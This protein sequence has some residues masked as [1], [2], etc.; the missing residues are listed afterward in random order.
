M[1]YKFKTVTVNNFSQLNEELRDFLVSDVGWTDETPSGQD[2][3]MGA[4]DYHGILGTFLRSSGEDGNQDIRL[5]LHQEQSDDDATV[6]YRTG[7]LPAFSYLSGTLAIG[8]SSVSVD[9][10]TE[11]AAVTTPFVVR[12]N[13]ELAVVSNVSGGTVTFSLRGAYGTAEAA[14]DASDVILNVSYSLPRIDVYAYRD[15]ATALASSSGTS[16]LGKKSVTGVPGLSGYTDDEFNLH[17]MLKVTDGAEA[18][19]MRPILDYAGTGGDFDYVAFSKAPGTANCE[20]VSMGFLPTNSKK[21]NNG[22]NRVQPLVR[23]AE[24]GT[25]TPCWFYASKDAVWVITKW[26]TGYDSFFAGNVIPSSSRDTTTSVG[27]STAGTASIDVVNRHLFVEG[28][29][30]RIISQNAD[31]WATNYSRSGGEPDLDA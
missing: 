10:D 23:M 15:L 21:V 30:F 19:K 14:H 29:K 24:A 1:A 7:R 18:G 2:D 28:E 4:G 11:L 6:E 3:E 31:D 12:M 26:N 25:D 27:T 5:H 17:G 8:A 9:D 22:G 16:S 20:I 13:D